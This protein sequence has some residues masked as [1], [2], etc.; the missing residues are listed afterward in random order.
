[1][2]LDVNIAGMTKVLFHP[3]PEKDEKGWSY[4]S[5]YFLRDL[6]D[7]FLLY[8]QN[9]NINSIND[10]YNLCVQANVKSENNKEWTPRN[11]LELVN[12]L[13][14]FD[15]L[16]KK[17]CKP[18]KADVF[19]T[20]IN[21]PLSYNDIEVFKC[22]YNHYFRFT[23]FHR[24]FQNNEEAPA[25][26]YAY[27]DDSRFFNR[28][29]RP[30]LNLLYCIEDDRKDVM[31]FW[32]VYTKWGTFLGVL[33][34]CSLKSMDILVED[35]KLY[36]AY[37]LN[38]ITDIPID[39]SVLNYMEEEIGEQYV[40]IPFLEWKV[41]TQYGFS[42]DGIKKKLIEECEQ[43]SSEYRLQRT[44]AIFINNNEKNL[45]PEY[46]NTYMSHILKL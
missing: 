17:T 10:L 29:I 23:E 27:M 2:R 39:F 11:L 26:I 1:M 4:S 5:V 32:D 3:E 16:D 15:L 7:V 36:N 37:L 35:D 30:D 40:Y 13:K 8:S 28:F 12:A 44:S 41:I 25:I 33:N 22:I 43:R 45:F 18:L 34:K 9:E 42:L 6:K 38:R 20:E 19:D 31:R 14:N 21:E 24:L 46:N